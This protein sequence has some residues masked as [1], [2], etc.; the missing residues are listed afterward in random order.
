MGCG[1]RAGRSHRPGKCCGVKAQFLDRQRC[2]WPLRDREKACLR[3]RKVPDRSVG[4]QVSQTRSRARTAQS[5]RRGDGRGLHAGCTRLRHNMQGCLKPRRA[6]QHIQV[7]NGPI[8][9]PT[10]RRYRS[11]RRARHIMLRSM[12]ARCRPGPC[13]ALAISGIKLLTPQS[14][15]MNTPTQRWCFA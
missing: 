9:H 7:S 3:C 1:P 5:L 8:R 4:P 11:L 13:T 6:R 14:G 2:L 15:G 10:M 12:L